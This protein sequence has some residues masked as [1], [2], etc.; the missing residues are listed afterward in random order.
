[1]VGVID[2]AKTDLTEEQQEK[3]KEYAKKITEAMNLESVDVN[4]MAAM[5]LPSP[6]VASATKQDLI[7]HMVKRATSAIKAGLW[8]GN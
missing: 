1:M 4:A 7:A 3:I 8:D 2:M 5:I 6:M